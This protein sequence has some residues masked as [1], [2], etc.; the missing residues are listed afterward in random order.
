MHALLLLCVG[1][2]LRISV[3]RTEDEDKVTACSLVS[4]AAL[5]VLCQCKPSL[6]KLQELACCISHVAG[7]SLLVE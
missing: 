2:V 5:S 6:S 7:A 3:D 1:D 4:S